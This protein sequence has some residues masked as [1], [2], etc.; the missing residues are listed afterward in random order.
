MIKRT[1]RYKFAISMSEDDWGFYGPKAAKRKAVAALNKIANVSAKACNR[2][3]FVTAVGRE[4]VRRQDLG[5]L[6]P[7][8]VQCLH[9]LAKELFYEPGGWIAAAP[10]APPRRRTIRRAVA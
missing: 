2:A 5:G 3:T 7:Q 4:L 6:Q 10:I 1:V 8:A 9:T